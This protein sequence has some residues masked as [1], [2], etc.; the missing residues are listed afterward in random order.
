LGLGFK[1]GLYFY[2]TWLREEHCAF[3]TVCRMDGMNQTSADER[4][5]VLQQHD[6]VCYIDRALGKIN[7]AQESQRKAKGIKT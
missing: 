1:Q 4:L 6:D 5:H 7:W 2:V 3:M